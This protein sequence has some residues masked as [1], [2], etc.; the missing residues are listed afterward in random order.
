MCCAMDKTKLQI[1]IPFCLPLGQ[2]GQM[3]IETKPW[4]QY[5]RAGADDLNGC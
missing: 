2:F 5:R 4:L 3:G 1:Y